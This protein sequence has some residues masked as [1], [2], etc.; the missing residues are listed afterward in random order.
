MWYSPKRVYF[1][2]QAR[3]VSK[4]K[5]KE[6]TMTTQATAIDRF[7]TVNGLRL[8]YLDW[9]NA[10]APPLIMLHGL[11]SFAH[12]WDV[13]S[14]QFCDRYHILALDQRGRGDSNW[15]PEGNYFTDVYVSDLEQFVDQL[16][17]NRFVLMG[18]SMG[19]ANAIV[20]AACHLEKVAV[21]VIEDIGPRS[22]IAPPTGITRIARELENTPREFASW[23]EAEAFWRGQRPRISQEAMEV[24]LANTLKALPNGKIVWKYDIEGITKA[25][26]D[27]SRQVDLWPHVRALG[28]PALLLRGAH[29]DILSR[30]TAQEM[31]RANTNIRWVEIPDA[32][33]SVHDDNT[34]AFNRELARFLESTK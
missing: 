4:E 7:T 16:G 25:R 12:D 17:L 19:G 30:E 26:A 6:N 21:L 11:R 3:I 24:R 28:C 33:H 1:K 2:R 23:D 14:R 31:A 10:G 8:H 20:Y 34:A 9:G 13:V 15:D 22:P 32:S 18:H 29:S 5:G 27:T